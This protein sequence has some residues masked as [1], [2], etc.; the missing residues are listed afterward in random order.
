MSG[1]KPEF[2]EGE[3]GPR[4]L[5]T[6][7][8]CPFTGGDLQWYAEILIESVCYSEFEIGPLYR[9]DGGRNTHSGELE[10]FLVRVHPTNEWDTADG[11]STVLVTLDG[12]TAEASWPPDHSGRL[13]TSTTGTV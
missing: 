10:L 3:D 1:D 9:L 13:S 6:R 12:V 2:F 5:F 7:D 8:G 11:V 4:Y